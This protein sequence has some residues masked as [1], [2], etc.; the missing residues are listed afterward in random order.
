[1]EMNI[2]YDLIMKVKKANGNF[3][4]NSSIPAF[5]LEG[6]LYFGIFLGVKTLLFGGTA[7]DNISMSAGAAIGHRIVRFFTNHDEYSSFSQSRRR[8]HYYDLV[9]LSEEAEEELRIKTNAKLL[10]S[11]DTKNKKKSK[12]VINEGKIPQIH[13]TRYITILENSNGITRENYLVQKHVFGSREY[14]LSLNNSNNM[15]R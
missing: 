13:Q 3:I 12:L 14:E 8:K 7:S 4:L 9:S 10:L 5:L 15:S 11:T 2:N 6:V 1:M